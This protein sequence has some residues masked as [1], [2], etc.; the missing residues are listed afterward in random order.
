ML[1]AEPLELESGEFSSYV[2]WLVI[3]GHKDPFHFLIMLA[4][5]GDDDS[6]VYF[7]GDLLIFLLEEQFWR[8][9]AR[10]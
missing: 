10:N 1:W 4:K 7:V 2:S 5:K 9:S 3:V 8:V 6:S